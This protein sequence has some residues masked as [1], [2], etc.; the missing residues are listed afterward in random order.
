MNDSLRFFWADKVFAIKV[1]EHSELRAVSV[2]TVSD[3][4]SPWSGCQHSLTPLLAAR[5]LER[6][7]EKQLIWSIGGNQRV[8]IHNCATINTCVV[9]YKSLF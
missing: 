9:L 3:T 5:T 8:R 2:P 4:E 6:L 1:F 7:K